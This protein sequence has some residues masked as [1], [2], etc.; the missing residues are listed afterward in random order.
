MPAAVLATVTTDMRAVPE[1]AVKA[2]ALTPIGVPVSG[3]PVGTF[4]TWGGAL[5]LTGTNRRGVDRESELRL[6]GDV[7]CEH[8]P[9]IDVQLRIELASLLS[10]V[11]QLPWGEVI[12]ILDQSW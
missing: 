1:R 10:I 2:A 5:V 8:D 4:S 11:D 9:A 6:R 7:K 3:P 12:V